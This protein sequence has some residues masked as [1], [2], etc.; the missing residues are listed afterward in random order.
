MFWHSTVGCVRAVVRG[1]DA[2]VTPRT[3]H[4]FGGVPNRALGGSVV[5]GDSNADS[6]RGGRA[7]IYTGTA[8]RPPH[9]EDAA[10]WPR[11]GWIELTSG[12]SLVRNQPCPP[13]LT[14]RFVSDKI[15]I[16][17]LC[18]SACSSR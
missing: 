3:A 17:A 14:R 18:S 4:R 12:G 8:S 16:T 13:G 1:A 2:A 9:V 10:T 11:T 15:L 5:P 7:R 6:H